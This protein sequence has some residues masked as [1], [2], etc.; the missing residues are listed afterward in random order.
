MHLSFVTPSCLI[1][2]NPAYFLPTPISHSPGAS[3]HSTSRTTEIAA[4]F[5][6]GQVPVGVAQLGHE[7]LQAREGTLLARTAAR[8]RNPAFFVA[9][10]VAG[11]SSGPKRAALLRR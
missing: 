8:S 11:V 4:K 5:H 1:C 3:I 10:F 9:A 6:P 2:T 7:I